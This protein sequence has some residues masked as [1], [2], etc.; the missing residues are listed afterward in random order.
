M[1]HGFVRTDLEF[2]S[3]DLRFGICVQIH[4][5][6]FGMSESP[7]RSEET[8]SDCILPAVTPVSF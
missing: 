7:P 2:V 1:L 4:E 8:F 3:F 5:T 6:F